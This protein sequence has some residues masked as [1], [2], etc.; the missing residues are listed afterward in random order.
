MISYI[1]N[2]LRYVLAVSAS[3][4][5]ALFRGGGARG[6]DRVAGRGRVNSQQRVNTAGHCWW[7]SLLRAAA[8]HTL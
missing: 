5:T 8:V 4:A 6:R 2:A 1:S 7:G 3:L